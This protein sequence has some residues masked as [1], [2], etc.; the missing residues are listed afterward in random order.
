MI[1]SKIEHIITGD[2]LQ[3]NATQ[4]FTTNLKKL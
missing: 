3:N 2:H 1:V 4:H